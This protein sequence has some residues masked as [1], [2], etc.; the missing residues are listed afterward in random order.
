MSISSIIIISIAYTPSNINSL[1]I[2]EK[3][4]K[5]TLVILVYSN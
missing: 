4:V 5:I 2:S 1:F 3:V